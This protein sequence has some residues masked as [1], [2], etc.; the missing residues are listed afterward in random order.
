MTKKIISLAIFVV[1][2]IASLSGGIYANVRAAQEKSLYTEQLHYVEKYSSLYEKAKES[3]N[4]IIGSLYFKNLYQEKTTEAQQKAAEIK[5]EMKKYFAF[6]SVLIFVAIAMGVCSFVAGRQL[7]KMEKPKV[8]KA[9]AD[10]APKPV[11]KAKEE[12][13]KIEKRKSDFDLILE[14]PKPSIKDE[15]K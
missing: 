7:V 15:N 9:E 13:A 2:L 11:M 6:A 4:P 10:D 5:K 8:K 12:P 14:A 3:N 1:M